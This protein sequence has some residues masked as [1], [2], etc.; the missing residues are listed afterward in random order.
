MPKKDR[1]TAPQHAL[2]ELFLKKWGV[3]QSCLAL[4]SPSTTRTEGEGTTHLVG[5]QLV[6]QAEEAGGDAKQSEAIQ[7]RKSGSGSAQG[8]GVSGGGGEHGSGSR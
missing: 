7:R 8:T 1:Q 4:P 3:P 2:R 5:T 6:K